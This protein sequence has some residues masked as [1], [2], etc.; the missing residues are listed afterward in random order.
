[1]K[2]KMPITD[3]IEI[4]KRRNRV[5]P[6]HPLRAL[7]MRL[8]MNQTQFAVE[9]IGLKPVSGQRIVSHWERGLSIPKN[10]IKQIKL[11]VKARGLCWNETDGV[12]D[13]AEE[14]RRLA[15]LREEVEALA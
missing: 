10:R 6:P 4:L 8:S 7:R 5:C 3:E 9:V 13:I 15:R 1:M 11:Y 12:I 14:E 2:T